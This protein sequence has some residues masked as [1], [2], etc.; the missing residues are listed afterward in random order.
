MDESE[1]RELA[2]LRRRAYGRGAGP[3][4][5][6]PEQARLR[7]L[8]G[9]AAPGPAHPDP[10]EPHR[11]PAEAPETSAP[12][13]PSPEPPPPAVAGRIRRRVTVLWAL[14]VV[15][16]AVVASAATVWVTG[17]A[18]PV[19]AVLP[20]SASDRWT[21]SG[22]ADVVATEDFHGLILLRSSGGGPPTSP[23][24]CLVAVPTESDDGGLVVNGCSAG[25]FPAVAQTTVRNGMPEELVAEFGEGTGLRFTLDGDTV[26]VQT[27]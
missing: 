16:T 26:R 5:E 15:T 10:H 13:P 23:D 8:E 1:R 6:A 25:S 7:L 11:E 4:L 9:R 14:S 19:V 12:V 3:E 18:D 17:S 27:D 22:F 21:G 2:E 20:L 24:Q